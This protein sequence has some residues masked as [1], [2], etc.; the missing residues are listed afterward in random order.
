ML[1]A[2]LDSASTLA[3]II[4]SDELTSGHDEVSGIMGKAE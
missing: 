2:G 4:A 1:L 3:L